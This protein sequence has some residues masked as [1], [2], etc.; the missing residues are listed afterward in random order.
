[1]ETDILRQAHREDWYFVPIRLP[2]SKSPATIPTISIL[3]LSFLHWTKK[4]NDVVIHQS[5][6]FGNKDFF[7][8]EDKQFYPR[9]LEEES[10]RPQFKSLIPEKVTPHPKIPEKVGPHP[11]IL[12]QSNLQDINHL[13]HTISVIMVPGFEKMP[14]I[15]FMLN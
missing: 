1:M 12:D 4:N 6:E 9:A 5:K 7:R 14:V 13:C 15:N 2:N 8:E 3:S 10:K 11:K